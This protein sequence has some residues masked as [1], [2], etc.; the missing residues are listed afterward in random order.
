MKKSNLYTFLI[1]LFFITIWQVLAIRNSH[2][3]YSDPWK[4]MMA[5]VELTKDGTLFRYI[6]ASLFRITTGFYL[7]FIFA[8]PLGLAFGTWK[9]LDKIAG[10]FIQFFRPISPLAWIP[11]AMVWFGI[12]DPPAVFLIFLSTFFPLLVPIIAAVRRIKPKYFQIGTNFDFSRWEK[13]KYI[14]IPAIAPD[15]VTAIRVAVGVGWLVVVAAEM[16]AVK[17]GLGYLIIDARNALRM[18]QVIAAMIVIGVIG[19]FIDRLIIRL[20][21]IR[22][23]EWKIGRN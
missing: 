2:G 3:Q 13:V 5:L 8:L 19:M 6:V 23:L 7:A 18:D 1:I 21:K 14:L 16:I 22:L 9:K 10:N 11:L 20:E 15:V 17:S 4:V 12:G